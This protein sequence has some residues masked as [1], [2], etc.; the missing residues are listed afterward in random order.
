MITGDTGRI[1]L[2]GNLQARTAMFD[3]IILLAGP[4][5]HVA[6]PPLLHEHNPLLTLIS[7]ETSA[8]LAVPST[9]LLARARL[10]AFVTPEIVLKSMLTRL[11]YGAF[12]RFRSGGAARNIPAVPI[13]RSATFL[14]TFPRMNSTGGSGYSATTI[15]ESARPSI[16]T[17]SS[18]A[19]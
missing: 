3:T 12:K 17:A 15:L 19:R 16:C 8:D 4:A 7:A 9:D 14:S 18:F 1:A 2:R 10:I 5:E 11:G 6:M 13:G